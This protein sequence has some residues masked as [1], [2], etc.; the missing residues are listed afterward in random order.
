MDKF[1]N[2]PNFQLLVCHRLDGTKTI[3][4]LCSCG[5]GA[6]PPVQPDLEFERLQA[7]NS[8]KQ[9]RC[10]YINMRAGMSKARSY[11]SLLSRLLI[12]TFLHN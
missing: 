4:E 3:S 11:V 8:P 5:V 7:E 12:P 10:S 2:Q 6:A 1:P 9:S